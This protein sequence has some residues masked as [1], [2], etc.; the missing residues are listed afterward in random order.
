VLLA[1]VAV[2]LCLV[3]ALVFPP[4]GRLPAQPSRGGLDGEWLNQGDPGQRC[5]IEVRGSSR[6]PGGRDGTIF[7]LRFFNERGDASRGVFRDIP[8]RGPD[9]GRR[10]VLASDWNGLRGVVLPGNE[11]IVWWGAGFWT[12]RPRAEASWE[13]RG[14]CRMA[15]DRGRI[16][17]VNEN[18]DSS[19]VDL[20]ENGLFY[21]RDWGDLP[22]Q[23]MSSGDIRWD[24]GTRWS[25]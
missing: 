5:G 15:F 9:E 21:A 25:R 18:G 22:G 1:G 11:V 6:A 14:R 12:R 13:H 7:D 10:T 3:L 23:F 4:P 24:N 2:P 17:A 19:R 20:R 16:W 8:G